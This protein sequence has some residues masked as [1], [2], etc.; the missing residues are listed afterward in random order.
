MHILAGLI[1]IL[2]AIATWYFRLKRIG[3]AARDMGRVAGTIR[4]APRKFAFMR[5][6]KHTGLKSVSD[7]MEAAAILMVLVAGARSGQDMDAEARD[8][9]RQE[10]MA[11][12][13]ITE[14]DVD[15]LL[16]HAL[17]MV[18]DVDVPSGVI[19]RMT[20]IIRKSPEI[21]DKELINL[22]AIL[23][24]ITEAGGKVW[25][26]RLNLLQLFRDEAGLRA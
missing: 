2:G 14:E 18:R 10:S 11:E 6:A 25:P 22:D 3:S 20:R 21:G 17:W 23:I 1:V 7:P 5:R 16:T 8:C 24:A 26:E 19:S 4:N 9:I 15:A 13:Q 12:F